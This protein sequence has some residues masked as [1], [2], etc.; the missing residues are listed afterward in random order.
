L[1]MI[2]PVHRSIT[3]VGDCTL[4]QC[5]VDTVQTWSL[6]TDMLLNTG[7]TAL[8]FFTRETDSI[9]LNYELYKKCGNDLE[10]F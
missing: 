9:Y 10:I 2:L 7:Q 8:V 5:E 1:Q 3:T 6:D 4:L